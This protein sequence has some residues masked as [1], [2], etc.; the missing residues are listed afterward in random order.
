MPVSCGWGECCNHCRPPAAPS[1]V[2]RG[3]GGFAGEE[4][5]RKVDACSSQKL[6]TPRPWRWGGTGGEVLRTAPRIG[7][8]GISLKTYPGE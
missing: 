1:W 6:K 2:S 4:S 3:G 8:I 5:S 7:L